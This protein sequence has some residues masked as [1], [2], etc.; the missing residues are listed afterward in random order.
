MVP[1]HT[2]S[3][4]ATVTS[5]PPVVIALMVL[6]LV[7]FGVLAVVRFVMRNRRR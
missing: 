7:V 4:R 1:M 5:F 2:E 3:Y 6:M